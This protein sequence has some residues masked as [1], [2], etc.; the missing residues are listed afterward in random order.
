MEKK[1]IE[2]K[3]YEL[4]REGKLNENGPV[5]VVQLAKNLGFAIVS[6]RTKEGNDD[7]DGFLLMNEDDN[8][9]MGSKSSRLIGI[10]AN[11]P[12]DVKRFIVAHELGHYK[13]T[14]NNQ[15]TFAMRD[16]RHGRSDEENEIDYFAACL[17]M[18]KVGF[19]NY[20]EVVKNEDNNNVIKSLA[21]EF[22]VPMD[23][24]A[25]RLQELELVQWK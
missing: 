19:K 4:L 23:S 20:Y 17:L 21:E 2:A 5:D 12:F 3:A 22:K 9:I 7:L 10:N 6:I 16:G 11:R 24:V 14:Y 15:R 18:P 1:E 13:L 25:R 8:D